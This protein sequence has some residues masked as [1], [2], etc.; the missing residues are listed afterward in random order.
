MNDSHEGRWAE[1]L[2]EALIADQSMPMSDDDR[3]SFLTGYRL[4]R[5]RPF[6]FCLSSEPDIL[7]QWRAYANDGTGV[8]IGF[9]SSLFPRQEHFPSTNA[10]AALNTGL[11]P[12]IY[13]Y[14]KQQA[15]IRSLFDEARVSP[16]ICVV[17]GG[18]PEYQLLGALL[19]GLSPLLKNPAFREEKELRLIHTPMLMT[20]SM[21]KHSVVG[22]EYV[23]GQ[24]VSNDQIVTHF[25]FPLPDPCIDVVKEVWIGPRSRLGVHDIELSL[26]LNEYG[27]VVV[28]KSSATYR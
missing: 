6:L 17:E 27:K 3:H 18:K 10:V 28:K 2:V 9:S 23:I 15:A 12:V 22:T 13:E 14:S 1:G 5:P 4:N 8:A 16:E 20:D 25:E 21:N 24:R 7:S 26:A 19:A 11:W